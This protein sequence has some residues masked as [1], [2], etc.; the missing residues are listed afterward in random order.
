MTMPIRN[1][2]LHL[3]GLSIALLFA[4]CQ[5]NQTPITV[6]SGSAGDLDDSGGLSEDAHVV[7]ATPSP[8]LVCDVSG[9]G[10]VEL[11]VHT[12][13]AYFGA[14]QPHGA[15]LLIVDDRCRYVV[16]EAS[17]GPAGSLREGV[18]DATQLAELN[19]DL[20]TLPWAALAGDR[21]D[22]VG[23]DAPFIT[24]S[25]RMDRV[26]CFS[27]CVDELADLAVA[28]RSWALRLWASGTP[29]EGGVGVHVMQ[30]SLDPPPVGAPVWDGAAALAPTFGTSRATLRIDEPDDA[31]R[32]RMLRA[33][34]TG[35]EGLTS[36]PPI[37]LFDGDT[38]LQVGVFDRS[39][40]PGLGLHSYQDA[41][42]PPAP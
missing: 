41:V 28:S 1:R 30:S 3:S 4:G 8:P 9:S 33:A 12:S 24:Y 11:A 15:R 14:Y 39:P 18:L 23:A 2:S 26:R 40:Y 20:L 35:T 22:V 13:D 10:V 16:Y 34:H 32:L 17:E 27:H 42:F 7:D 29:L 21:S 38:L 6:D 25:R 36:V 5:L 31:A 19:A 37:T